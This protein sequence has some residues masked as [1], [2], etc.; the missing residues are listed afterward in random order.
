MNFNVQIQKEIKTSKKDL[1]QANYLSLLNEATF[2]PHEQPAKVEMLLEE[3]WKIRQF[4]LLSLGL[5]LS[6]KD[7]EIY[8]SSGL[9]NGISSFLKLSPLLRKQITEYPPFRIWL[10]QSVAMSF[11]STYQVN[12]G[13][14]NFKNKLAEL[15][16]VIARFYEN[17]KSPHLLKIENNLIQIKRFDVDPLLAEVAPPS[18]QFPDKEKQYELEKITT[19]PVSFFLNVLTVALENIKCA[20][21]AAY[22][23]FGKFVKI[24]VHVTDADFRSCSANRFAGVIFISSD[25]RSLFDIEE[26]LIH[27]YGHQILYNVMELNPLIDDKSNKKFKLPWSGAERDFYG[28]FHAFYIY[29]LLALY[30]ERRIEVSLEKE[31]NR[32]VKRTSQ[33]LE[34]L[35]RAI[36]DFEKNNFFTSK[37]RELFYLLKQEV[38]QLEI[39]Q[40]N[41]LNIKIKSQLVEQAE[42]KAKFPE[43]LQNANIQIEINSEQNSGKRNT[44][45]LK[46]IVSEFDSHSTFRITAGCKRIEIDDQVILVDYNNDKYFRLQATA[47]FIWHLIVQ[48]F[49]LGEICKNLSQDFNFDFEESSIIVSNFI[50]ELMKIDIIALSKK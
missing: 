31:R 12:P 27:E 44:T 30:F 35:I 36:P 20:W 42:K 17:F 45:G 50:R 16:T 37:G 24:I 43:K 13:R 1:P 29:T 48:G 9:S 41:Q 2:L 22:K 21:P 49:T 18:Y 33:I 39:R 25:D 19:Y 15:T 4:T 8:D 7:P 46:P 40:R 14:N 5:K 28:Y 6:E 32:G 26:S 23:D 38:Y 47:S 10:R 34:G 11:C 3:V